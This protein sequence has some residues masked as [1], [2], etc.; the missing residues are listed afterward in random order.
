MQVTQ[1]VTYDELKRI[2]FL[3]KTLQL[4]SFRLLSEFPLFNGCIEIRYEMNV[5]ECNRMESFMNDETP[6]PLTKWMLIKRK[7]KKWLK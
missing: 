7:I 5:E 2:Q 1:I 4:D 6:K 3:V